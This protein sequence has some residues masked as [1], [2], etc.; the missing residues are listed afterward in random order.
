VT[1]LFTNPPVVLQ[2][3]NMPSFQLVGTISELSL[4]QKFP[5]INLSIKPYPIPYGAFELRVLQGI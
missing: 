1:I 3:N 2:A 5:A 4:V